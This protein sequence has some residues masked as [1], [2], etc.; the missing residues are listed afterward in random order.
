MTDNKEIDSEWILLIREA[1]EIL[2][3]EEIR[4]FLQSFTTTN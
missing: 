4:E 2:S 3:E 1:L